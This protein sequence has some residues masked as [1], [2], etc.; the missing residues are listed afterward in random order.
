M[1]QQ[2]DEQ[3]NFEW[4]RQKLLAGKQKENSQIFN[5]DFYL[6]L[7]LPLC[8]T[9]IKFSSAEEQTRTDCLQQ[10]MFFDISF[11]FANHI[12][13]WI[14]ANYCSRKLFVHNQEEMGWNFHYQ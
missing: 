1:T 8:F 3:L 4:S 12:A 11:I 6:P 10:I 2:A 5:E 13:E 14:L 7:Y 9:L